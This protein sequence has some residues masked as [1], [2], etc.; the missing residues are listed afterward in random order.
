[1]VDPKGMSNARAGKEVKS[2][3]VLNAK[4]LRLN[5]VTEKEA[6]RM[7]VVII[8]KQLYNTLIKAF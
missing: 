2:Q 6:V 3:V 8:S 4:D 5:P 7:T 1:M